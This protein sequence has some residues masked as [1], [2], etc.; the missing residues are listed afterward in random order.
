MSEL[1]LK[2]PTTLYPVTLWVHPEGRVIGSLFLRDDQTDKTEDVLT[3]VN[4]PEQFLVFKCE[5]PSEIRFYN[6]SSIIRMEY[7]DPESID[8]DNKSLQCQLHMMDGSLISG[9]IRES[10][11]ADHSRLYDYLNLSENRFLRI[12]TNN[13]EVILVNK[14]YV[15]QVTIPEK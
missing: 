1:D 7:D 15:N 8:A 2:I 13:G 11:P 9:T 4:Y 5:T 14:T 6:R 12:H 3:L 10:L